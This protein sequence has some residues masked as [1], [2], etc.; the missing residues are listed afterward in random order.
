MR[1]WIIAGAG[2][3]IVVLFLM[4]TRP[5]GGRSGP[6]QE[7]EF[8][9]VE[10]TRG[11]L[12]ATVGASGVVEADQEAILTFQTTGTVDQ[13][14]VEVGSTVERGD[15]LVT[16]EQSSLSAQIILAQADLV[17][18][19]DALDALFDTESALAGAEL[20]LAQ[21]RDEYEAAVYRRDVLQEGNRA[22][23]ETIAATEANLILAQNEVDRAQDEYSKYSGRP[24]DDP[25]RALARSNLAAAREKRDSIQRQLNWYLGYPSDI[26]Q[27]ILDAE[28][29][30]AL[31]KLEEAEE[32]VDQLQSGP[33][34][35]EIASAQAGV[36]A[37]E[38][39]LELA[40]ITAP[41]SGTI[42]AVEVK[43][44]DRVSTNQP[45]VHLFD[46]DPL[47]VQADITEVD[48]NKV[49]IGQA[50]IL[51][52]DAVL[53]KQY[54]GEVVEVGLTGM[55]VQGIVNFGL[56]I[57]LKI[58][59]GEIHPGLTAA[60]N[61]VVSEIEDALLVPNRAVRVED[62]QRVVFVSRGGA[63]E[64]VPVEL[65]ATSESFSEVIGGDLVEGD[66]I[67]LNPPVEFEPG[68]GP[69]G[70]FFGG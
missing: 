7:N 48:I 2:I 36:A 61:V 66:L 69:G 67:I 51:N 30:L 50:V 68:G 9:T 28:V 37:A 24:E 15:I 33:D 11:S 58:P 17:A 12:R 47:F 57:E 55:P 62:G 16:L 43:P 41:F 31:S 26:D 20:V 13:V 29:K 42:T 45:A 53:G 1:R 56:K 60:V 39:T 4:L 14:L 19:Q 3:I 23:G 38:A 40:Q 34:A 63:L 21:A 6:T 54:E 18:A 8:Q 10:A 52:F 5:L 44:G 35:D 32:E 46:L 49:Q 65:G 59:G 22:S 70:G 25:V 27:A 64:A